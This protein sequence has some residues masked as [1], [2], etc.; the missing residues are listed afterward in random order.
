MKNVKNETNKLKGGC[1]RM[2]LVTLAASVL[3]SMLAG[4]PKIPR[5]KK[6]QVK[7]LIQLVKEQL[8]QVGIFNAT[9]SFTNL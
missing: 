6:K 8:E 1:L 7:E 9:S 2:L 3:G 5:C 4:K